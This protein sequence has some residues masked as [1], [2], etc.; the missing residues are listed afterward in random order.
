[1]DKYQT[2]LGIGISQPRKGSGYFNTA[3]LAY[4]RSTTQNLEKRG[5]HIRLLART[6]PRWH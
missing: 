5:N 4:N 1:M 3:N 6:R 2:K